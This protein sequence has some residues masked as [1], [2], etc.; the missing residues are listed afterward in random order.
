MTDPY[1]FFIKLAVSC[2]ITFFVYKDAGVKKVPYR[3]F[4]VVATFLFPAIALVYLVYKKIHENK[5]VLTKK[6]EITIA[7]N[8]Q[9]EARKKELAAER[10]AFAKEQAKQAPEVAA[11]EEV[12]RQK[13]KEELAWER[14][15]QQDR[16]AK[17]MKLK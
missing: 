14:K 7:Y 17:R 5:V 3:D 11:A 8:K 13:Q 6:Q 4:W 2:L 10:E 12:Q 16:Q 1:S 15:F 9:V